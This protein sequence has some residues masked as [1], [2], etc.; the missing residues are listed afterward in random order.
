MFHQSNITNRDRGLLCIIILSVVG[1]SIALN[2]EYVRAA[3][4]S[5]PLTVTPTDMFQ[6]SRAAL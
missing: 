3:R 4:A 6:G 1:V 5:C 2:L